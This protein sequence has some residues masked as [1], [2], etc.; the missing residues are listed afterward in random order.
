[1]KDKK[2]KSSS[3]AAIYSR[4]ILIKRFRRSDIKNLQLSQNKA[5][6]LH[7]SSLTPLSSLK[8]PDKIPPHTLNANLLTKCDIEIV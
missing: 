6:I 1:M 8:C 3:S 4:I 2:Y 7:N 5:C